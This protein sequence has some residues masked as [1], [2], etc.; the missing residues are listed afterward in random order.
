MPRNATPA[1]P[2]YAAREDTALLVPFAVAGPGRYVLEVGCGQGTIALAAARS[3]ARVVATDLNPT[4][5]ARLRDTAL[6]EGLAV[7]VVRTDLAAGLGRFDRVLAN[8]PYLPTPPAAR[9][10]DPWVNLALDGGPDG[11]GP[12]RRLMATLPGHL[13]L[14][15]AAY[16]LL[17]T[18]QPEAG[19]RTLLRRWS[20]VGGSADV[21]ASTVLG[22]ERLEVWRFTAPVA[23]R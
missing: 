22:D 18:R 20:A 12:T 4:A 11:L 10:P 14:G 5:L 17:S 1:R 3:G 23:P 13:R 21:A 2:V 15:G 9:D 7:D 8:P 6:A 16:V 19:R